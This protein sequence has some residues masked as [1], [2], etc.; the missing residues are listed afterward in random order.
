[1]ASNFVPGRVVDMADKAMG[2]MGMG[3]Q[4]EKAASKVTSKPKADPSGATMKAVQWNGTKSVSVGD[5]A[6]PALTD[7]CDCIIRVTSTAICGSD[8]HL[9]VNNVPGMSSGHVL[10]HEAMGI[11]ESVGPGVRCVKEGDRVV[12]AFC[13]AC[14]ECYYCQKKLF[15]SCDRTNP[16]AVAEKTMGA[17]TAGLLGH[18]EIMGGYPG[19]QAEYLRIPFAD[20]NTLVLP[21]E[22]ELADEKVLFLSDVLSTAW[23]ATELA[24]VEPGDVVAIWGAGPV[25]QLTAQCAFARGAKRVILVDNIKYRLDAAKQIMPKLETVNFDKAAGT[26]GEERVLELC[27]NEPAGAPDCCI[28]CVGMHY[29][30]T[31]M[32]RAEMATGLETDSPETVNACIFAVRKGGRVAVIGAYAGLCNHFNIGALMEKC[33]VV[34][35]GQTPV[36]KYWKHLLE[37]IKAKKLDPSVIVSHHMPLE[38][39]AEAYKMFNEKT[40][41]VVKVILKPRQI[42]STQA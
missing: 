35:S 32:H 20:L 27:Q 28:D 9:Y 42:K 40:D 16:V 38:Q 23:H 11:V 10:G 6:K 21:P 26:S 24:E 17:R 15:T 29:A 36:Q 18:P 8:L 41:D 37:L 2:A 1:M 14:G 31:M 5:C 33:L 19:G 13:M 12:A 22:S 30:H 34:R 4:A 39:A 3:K 7:E 25:G